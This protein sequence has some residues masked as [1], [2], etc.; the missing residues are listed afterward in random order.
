MESQQRDESQQNDFQET[1]AGFRDWWSRHGNTVLIVV[2]VVI[3]AVAGYRFYTQRQTQQHNAAWRDLATATSP[4][5]LMQVAESHSLPA[6]QSLARLRAGDLLLQQA[7]S[8]DSSGDRSTSEALNEAANLYQTVIDND[9]ADPAMRVNALLGK[10][11]VAETQDNWD[12]A[13][14]VY[15]Q[16]IE[17][18]QQHQLSALAQQAE[19]RRAQLEEVSRP[20]TF[21]APSTQPSGQN[22]NIPSGA[23][24]QSGGGMPGLQMQSPPS[25]QPAPS[26]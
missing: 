15:G 8:P 23:M 4:D 13:R 9:A 16:A 18:G 3:L 7:V 11:A 6:V 14:E 22:M 24:P 10:A 17:L 2:T 20:V 1:M 19:G 25:T 26:P 5:T 12:Q 21:A